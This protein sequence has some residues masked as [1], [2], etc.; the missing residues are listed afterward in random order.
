MTTTRLSHLGARS[1]LALLAV[2]TAAAPPAPLAATSS[3]GRGRARV[4]RPDALR[5]RM[6]RRSA[7]GVIV[8]A[9]VVSL[10]DG[11]TIYESGPE[12]PLTPA[13]TMKILTG[14][15]IL[16]RLGPDWLFETRF[17]TD[18]PINN[19]VVD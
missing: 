14:A 19:G 5:Q 13:S 3:G 18:G 8:G 1:L 15:A 4:S 6:R 12:K 7:K 2:L 17:F 11:R 10:S 9:S 16:D